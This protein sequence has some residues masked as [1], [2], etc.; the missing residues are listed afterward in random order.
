MNISGVVYESLVDGVGVRTTIFISGCYHNCKGCQNPETQNFSNGK[1]FTL[2]LQ[3]EII[4]CIKE[5]QLIQGITLSGGDPVFSARELIKFI[6]LV[7][8]ELSDINIWCYTGFKF[9]ELVNS[10][11]IYIKQL[12][13]MCDVIVDGKFIE[14]QKDITLPFKGSKNQRIIDVKESLQQNEIII[15]KVR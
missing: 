15:Y 4:N 8:L 2:D 10:T 9:E 14:D 12:V 1:E 5:N 7:K 13:K 3:K 6:A 11:D